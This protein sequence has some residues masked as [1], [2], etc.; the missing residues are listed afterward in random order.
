M[1]EESEEMVGVG[2]GRTWDFLYKILQEGI[3]GVHCIEHHK[4]ACV[5]VDQIVKS[6]FSWRV[7]PIYNDG[8]FLFTLPSP[9][10]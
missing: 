2:I 6:K 9:S 4:R 8:G 1:V 3:K 5:L 7:D 10:T